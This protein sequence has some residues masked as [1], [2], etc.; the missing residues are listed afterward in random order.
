MS[1]MSAD[2]PPTEVPPS[3]PPATL[4]DHLPSPPLSREEC[5]RRAKQHLDLLL[6]AIESL[7]VGGSEAILLSMKDLGLHRIIPN[8]VSLWRLR[9]TNPMRKSSQRQPLSLAEAKA[10]TATIVNLARRQ[11]ALIRQLLIA[12]EQLDA[13][14][15]SLNHHF[16]LADYLTRF[17]AHFRAR[18]NPRRAGVMVYDTEEKLN[19]LA[20]GLLEQLLLC[21]GTSGLER[22]WISLFDG[23]VA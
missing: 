3:S 15:L 10:L 4:V 5:P 9:A 12:R 1:L 20:L 7:D 21:T 22:L 14:H 18:M 23:E 16:R 6:L 8:R 17:R 19:Q 13:K 2:R 11:T